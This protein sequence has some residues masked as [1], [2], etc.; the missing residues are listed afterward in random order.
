MLGFIWR[1][2]RGRAGRSVALSAGVLVATTGFVVLTGATTTSR[3]DV[4]GTVERNTQ[5]AY[6]ILVRPKGTRTPLEAERG[7]SAP[8][9]S[10]GS[11]AASPPSSTS[12]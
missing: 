3:L 8:T 9:I 6:E 4:T 11:S 12:R 5:V 7:W 1:Q 10:P 2:L